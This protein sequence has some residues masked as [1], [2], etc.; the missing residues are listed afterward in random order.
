M[1]VILVDRHKA[2]DVENEEKAKWLRSILEQI[3]VPLDNW[4]AIPSMDN[5]RKMR[6]LL[7]SLSID[8]IDD[9]DEGLDVYWNDKLIA[10]WKR[11][12][13]V[14]RENKKERDPQFRF[15]FE[16]HLKC[17]DVFNKEEK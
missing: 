7:K 13:Y 11:P 4:P 1:T 17:R 8:I 2:K 10:E 14:L 3:N 16:M 12:R 9:S 15:Y 6:V 5:L